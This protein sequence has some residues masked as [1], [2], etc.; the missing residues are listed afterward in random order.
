MPKETQKELSIILCAVAIASGYDS[1]PVA[2]ND[3][4]DY[5]WLTYQDHKIL[6][7]FHAD[8]IMSALDTYGGNSR[9]DMYDELE[10][11]LT[12]NKIDLVK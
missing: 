12:K 2:W 11:F 4:M 3:D 7:Q 6:E 10:S 1:V 8:T 9:S 5:F